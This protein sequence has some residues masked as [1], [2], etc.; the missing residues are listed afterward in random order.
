MNF[1]FSLF[2]IPAP[3]QNPKPQKKEQN[4]LIELLH[5]LCKCR[6]LILTIIIIIYGIHLIL[7]VV[8]PLARRE[9][10]FGSQLIKVEVQQNKTFLICLKSYSNFD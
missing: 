7:L 1:F 3:K 6:K 2:S 10:F 5:Y 8:I 9:C 4:F